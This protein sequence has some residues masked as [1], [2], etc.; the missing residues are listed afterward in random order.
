MRKSNVNY[1]LE[2]GDSVRVVPLDEKLT[3]N[4]LIRIV[5]PYYDGTF[6]KGKEWRR[7]AW[8][9]VQDDLFGWIGLSYSDY[10]KFAGYDD[11]SSY[12]FEIISVN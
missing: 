4:M 10:L 7:E 12:P 6:V 11:V 8:H 9:T 2:E 3:S 1:Y 5:N